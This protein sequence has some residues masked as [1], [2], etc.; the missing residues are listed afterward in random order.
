MYAVMIFLPLPGRVDTVKFL[1][2]NGADVNA[3]DKR[4]ETPLMFASAFDRCRVLKLLIDNGADVNAKDKGGWS[5]L[6][7]GAY[8]G[9]LA[10]VV[11]EFVFD[12]IVITDHK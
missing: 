8:N 1:I 7:Y 6:I 2:E 4:G 11:F 9:N 3:K 5:A 10:V 12:A